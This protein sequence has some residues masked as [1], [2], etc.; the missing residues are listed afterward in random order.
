MYFEPKAVGQQLDEEVE[1]IARENVVLFRGA[2]V[3]EV[4]ERAR[5]RGQADERDAG[6]DL[7]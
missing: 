5:E 1:F 7:T 3:D 4:R 2:G 6:D